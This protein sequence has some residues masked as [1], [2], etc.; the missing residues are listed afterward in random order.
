M[1]T[2]NRFAELASDADLS[3]DEADERTSSDEADNEI[4][5]CDC[6]GIDP[7]VGDRFTPSRMTISISAKR[8]LLLRSAIRTNGLWSKKEIL[9]TLVTDTALA[10][11]AQMHG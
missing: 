5:V 6:C 3:S 10:R 7:I 2:L 11:C 4:Y 9:E 8:A 1:E